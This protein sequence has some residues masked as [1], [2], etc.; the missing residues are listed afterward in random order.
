MGVLVFT[1]TDSVA[2]RRRL[3]V[4]SDR[5]AYRKDMFQ[6]VEAMKAKIRSIPKV[7]PSSR[8]DIIDKLV[9]QAA[10]RETS[11]RRSSA[12]DTPLANARGLNTRAMKARNELA[13]LWQKAI[14]ND[15]AG[16]VRRLED[17]LRSISDAQKR[18]IQSNRYARKIT[19]TYWMTTNSQICGKCSLVP[20]IMCFHQIG[21]KKNLPKARCSTDTSTPRVVRSRNKIT[22]P[23]AARMIS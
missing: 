10:K 8:A 9:E 11:R 4:F 16:H 17:R 23:I 21:R 6:K 3:P 20:N 13:A 18:V 15:E 19:Q 14:R 12:D 5:D 2:N 1:D 22:N 7:S